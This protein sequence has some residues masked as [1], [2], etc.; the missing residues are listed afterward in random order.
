[1]SITR[2]ARI[3]IVGAGAMGSGIA[4]IAAGSGH[5][6]VVVDANAAALAQSTGDANSTA[7]AAPAANAGATAFVDKQEPGMLRGEVETSEVIQ[8][9]ALS[10][11]WVL[12]AG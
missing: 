1:M 4:Q 2:E 11:L 7:K 8:P 10:R 3:G 12:P 5:P 9:T 6:V